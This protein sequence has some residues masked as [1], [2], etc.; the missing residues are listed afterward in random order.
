[1]KEVI[2]RER[3]NVREN[4]EWH[5]AIVGL[6]HCKYIYTTSTHNTCRLSVFETTNESIP[7]NIIYFYVTL[8]FVC[9]FLI[10]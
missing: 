7:I 4:L 6:T 8:I 1:M 3:E 5:L 2:D 10:P 9:L